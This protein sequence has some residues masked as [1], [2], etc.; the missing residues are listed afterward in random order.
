MLKKNRRLMLK[1]LLIFFKIS[2]SFK[3]EWEEIDKETGYFPRLPSQNYNLV[4]FINGTSP[5]I[6]EKLKKF[7]KEELLIKKNV[8]LIYIDIIKTP[9]YKKFYD[10]EDDKNYLYFFIG[11]NLSIFEK[12]DE[13]IN[14]KYFYDITYNFVF[15]EIQKIVRKIEDL[16][17]LKKEIF[18]KDIIGAYLGNEKDFG[19]FKNLAIKNF[20]FSF[21]YSFDEGLIKKILNTYSPTEKDYKK[22]QFV[23]IR[24]KKLL[25]EFDNKKLVSFKNLK[26]KYYL[27]Q[28]LN[29]E[30]KPKYQKCSNAS[31]II[32][33]MFYK[34]E[35]LILHIDKK[36][37]DQKKKIEFEKAIKKLPKKLNYSYCNFGDENTNQYLQLFMRAGISYNSDMI[38]IIYLSPSRNTKILQFNS[39]EEKKIVEFVENFYK[40]NV[41]LFEEGE[42]RMFFSQE[43]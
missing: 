17:F 18:K 3:T 9:F 33:S 42:E 2:K 19:N 31:K 39:F 27:Q 36:I 26:K 30:R 28:F 25:D 12:F 22:N 13:S 5:K 29:F 4:I 37:T 7:E 35:V 40:R 16:R 6:I 34:N 32:D 41:F 1:I 38:Y 21:F 14:H 11:N 24:S 23:I 15:G 20:K 8:D 43:L 10:L